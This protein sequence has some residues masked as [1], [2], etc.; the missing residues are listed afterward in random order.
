MLESGAM[1]RVRRSGWVLGLFVG[2]AGCGPVVPVDDGGTGTTGEDSMAGSVE[3]TSDSVPPDPSAPSTTGAST[4]TGDDGVEVTSDDGPATATDSA[5]FICFAHCQPDGGNQAFEC[6][7]WVQDCPPGEK[8]MPWANDGGSSWNATRCSPLSP[9]PDGVGEPCVVEGSGV[10]G[11][12]TCDIHAMCWNVDADTNEG[13]CIALCQGTEAAPECAGCS[14]CFVANGGALPLCLPQC[15][16]LAQ[17]CG[18]FG[19]C[20]AF[21]DSFVCLP[22]PGG[23]AFGDPC[24]FDSACP[25]GQGCQ[26]AQD[27]PGCERSWGCC[28]PYCDTADPVACDVVPGLLCSPL[29]V[30]PTACVPGQIGVCVG[31]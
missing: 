15:D 2:A 16:P 29:G 28:T 31:A 26:P 30:E 4:T 22:S 18:G 5:G 12:D 20:Y 7:P 21:A 24:E 10:S 19:G 8:C 1:G 14:Q 13:T 23:G 9:D 3:G 25:A 17:D 6:D 11:V 27:V